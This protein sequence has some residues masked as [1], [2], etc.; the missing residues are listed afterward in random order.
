MFKKHGLAFED[1]QDF[2]RHHSAGHSNHS[3][4]S[5]SVTWRYLQRTGHVI[6]EV[7]KELSIQPLSG[8]NKGA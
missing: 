1:S 6:D 3:L 2:L 4:A 8:L 5:G 7:L